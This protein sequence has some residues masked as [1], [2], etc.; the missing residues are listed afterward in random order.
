VRGMIQVNAKT[1]MVPLA[2]NMCVLSF[3]DLVPGTMLNTVDLLFDARR[4]VLSKG[5]LTLGETMR[6]V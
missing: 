2:T 6:D 5:D 4:Y 3:E 1:P